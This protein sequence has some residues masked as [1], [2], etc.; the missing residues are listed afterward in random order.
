MTQIERVASNTPWEPIF[1]YVRKVKAGNW[2][3]I[4]GTTATDD[5]GMLVGGGQ[6]YVQARQTLLNLKHH[7]ESAGF[8][9]SN[10]VRTRVFVTD[11]S[12]FAEVARAHKEIFGAHPPAS[13][14]VEVRRLVH[15]DMLIEIEADVFG[16]EIST[17]STER[18]RP[19][20][21]KQT[22]AAPKPTPGAMVKAKVAPKKKPS[23]PV[24]RK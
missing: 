7:I 12:R 24:R 18:P 15:P 2:L 6:M 1:G 19:V 3:A 22:V 5:R 17:P 8:S 20:E 23:K 16:G 11:I 10:L 21:K 13:T 9:L 14:L 4:S